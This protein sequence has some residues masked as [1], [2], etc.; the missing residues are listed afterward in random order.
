M[1]KHEVQLQLQLQLRRSVKCIRIFIN[2]SHIEQSK[3]VR[4]KQSQDLAFLLIN[5]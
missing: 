3:F 1:N 5:I 2:H 4:A